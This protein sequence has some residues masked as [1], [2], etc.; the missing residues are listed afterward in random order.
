MENWTGSSTDSIGWRLPETGPPAAPDSA[1]QSVE[2][3]SRH[4]R[5]QSSRILRC[6]AEF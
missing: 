4:M 5:G 6:W 1:L 2:T 3:S